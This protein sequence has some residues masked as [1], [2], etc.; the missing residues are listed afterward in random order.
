MGALEN[1][2]EGGGCIDSLRTTRVT[3]DL[4]IYRSK[5]STIKNHSRRKPQPPLTCNCWLMEEM[6]CPTRRLL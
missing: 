6:K 3:S 4:S 1:G 2:W 5:V